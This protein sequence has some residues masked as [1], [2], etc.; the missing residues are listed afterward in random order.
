M[1][2][3]ANEVH[4]MTLSLHNG[5][6]YNVIEKVFKRVSALTRQ[7]QLEFDSVFLSEC[8][9]VILEQLACIRKLVASQHPQVSIEEALATVRRTDPV[10]QIIKAY[11]RHRL[12]G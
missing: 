11:T 6:S 4:E 2:Q 3:L 1:F 10:Y 5:G 12:R 8:V 9:Q 7:Q